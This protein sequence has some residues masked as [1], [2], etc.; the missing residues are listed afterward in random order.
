MARAVAAIL[1][2]HAGVPRTAVT[3]HHMDA[4]EDH[5]P[6]VAQE[7]LAL[8]PRT[9]GDVLYRQAG[10]LAA[11]MLHTALCGAHLKALCAVPQ[12]H[13]QATRAPRPTAEDVCVVPQAWRG[14]HLIDFACGA[15]FFRAPWLRLGDATYHVRAGLQ[16]SPERRLPGEYVT[17]GDRLM[18]QCCDGVA[19]LVVQA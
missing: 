8:T 5:G 6:I 13:H 12:A 7:T 1:G 14:A 2:I 10:A 18:V 19:T 4:Y 15:P 11:T 3:I 16:W 17:H 9:A